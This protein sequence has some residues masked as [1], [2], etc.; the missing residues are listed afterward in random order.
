MLIYS[1]LVLCSITYLYSLCVGIISQLVWSF[2]LGRILSNLFLHVVKTL[3]NEIDGLIIL[4]LILLNHDITYTINH[5]NYMYLDFSVANSYRPVARV[6]PF[7]YW[8]IYSQ[9]QV[10]LMGNQK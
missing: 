1:F 6:Y 8:P 10:A 7:Q 9:R 3:S 5:D 4:V 2:Y